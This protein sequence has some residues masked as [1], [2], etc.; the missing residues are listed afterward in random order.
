MTVE[1]VTR[2]VA[3]GDGKAHSLLVSGLQEGDV[4]LFSLDGNDFSPVLPTFGFETLKG[5]HFVETPSI[6]SSSAMASPSMARR[7]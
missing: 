4:L 2:F 5:Q 3:E 6:I 7:L 1:S